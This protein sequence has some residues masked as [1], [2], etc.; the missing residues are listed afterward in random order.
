MPNGTM[1][2]MWLFGL[3]NRS[4]FFVVQI[5]TDWCICGGYGMLEL[6]P[7]FRTRAN[8]WQMLFQ[9][10]YSD[11]FPNS[12]W[13]NIAAIHYRWGHI[14]QVASNADGWKAMW[15]WERSRAVW[16]DAVR[17]N[18]YVAADDTVTGHFG[19]LHEVVRYN[20]FTNKR[21]GVLPTWYYK[22]LSSG[23]WHV[24]GV[25]PVVSIVTQG[26]N[27]GEEIE[28]GGDTYLGFPV[29]RITDQYGFAFRIA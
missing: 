24:I 21:V 18:C 20:G 27:F 1:P 29:T 12:Y 25:H 8:Q 2:K 14:Q 28:F 23:L 5:T 7:E 9:G 13:Y 19:R 22:D 11:N 3:E 15:D 10:C 26:I 4:L 16:S 17:A 6:L